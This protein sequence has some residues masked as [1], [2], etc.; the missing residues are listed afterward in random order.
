MHI[1]MHNAS[2]GIKSGLSKT[3]WLI[4]AIGRREDGCVEDGVWT[5]VMIWNLKM[6]ERFLAVF[7]GIGEEGVD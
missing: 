7:S 6:E 2:I 4:G 3:G 1:K 5:L